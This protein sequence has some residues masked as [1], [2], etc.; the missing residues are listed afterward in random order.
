[1]LDEP[2]HPIQVVSRRTGLTPDVIRVWERRY[3]AVAPE[4]S[5]TNRRLYTDGD[6]ER[7]RLLRRA[8]LGGRA[9]GIVARLD[10]DALRRLVESDERTT[11]ADAAGPRSGDLRVPERLQEAL[12][13]VRDLAGPRLRSVLRSAAIE[14]G[15]PTLLLDLIVPLMREVGDGWER[16]SFRIHQEHL[17]TFHVRTLL[18]SLHEGH[19][20]HYG[21]PSLVVSTLAGEAHEIGASMAAV[22]AAA[23]GWEVSHLGPDLPAEEVVAA[24]VATRARAVALSMVRDRPGD[25]VAEDLRRLRSALPDSVTL[26]V[27]G[28][29]TAAVDDTLRAIGAV[30]LE[31]LGAFREALARLR[32]SHP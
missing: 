13:A 27:G 19:A 20:R 7:L 3:A 8:T 6:L 1:M 21:G 18:G 10:T 23:E 5:A 29:G 28:R 26:F 17:A 11:R 24:A 31:D 25:P 15:A 16:G 14:L 4:R 32:T 30:R 2:K 12:E 22:L 9:I